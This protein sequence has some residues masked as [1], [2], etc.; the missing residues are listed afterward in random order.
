MTDL[1]T[2]LLVESR[3]LGFLGPGPVEPHLHHASAFAA[4]VD[5][6]PARALDLGAGGGLPGLVLAASTWPDTRWTFVDAHARRSEF[7]ADAVDRLGLGDR[8]EVITDR[9]EEVGRSVAHRGRFDLVV[10]RSFG[11]PCV[12]AE[13]GAPLLVVGGDLVVSEP[14]VDRAGAEAGRWPPTGLALLGLGPASVI[15]AG[16]PGAPV[17]L[18]RMRLVDVVGERYPRRTGIPAKRPLF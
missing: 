18:A 11:P 9:A 13:C 8:V 16:S 14:P 10:A 1:L 5:R 17:H 3:Q 12:T 7:L 6:P 2:G 4:A 15:V